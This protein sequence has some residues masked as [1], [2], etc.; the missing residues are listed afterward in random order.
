MLFERTALSK[1]PAELAKQ[2][3]YGDVAHHLWGRCSQSS[4]SD[5][6]QA[7]MVIGTSD[8]D[9]LKLFKKALSP[10]PGQVYFLSMTSQM[11][12]KPV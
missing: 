10:R 6:Q 11:P 8:G 7:Q 5:L 2:V 1:K 3:I 12:H 4:Q 9:V